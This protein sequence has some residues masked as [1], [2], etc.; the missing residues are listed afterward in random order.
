MIELKN[1]DFFYQEE[2]YIL[3]NYNLTLLDNK[4]YWLQG[5][6]GTG[7]TTLLNILLGINKVNEGNCY[8]N[9]NKNKTLF[10][11]STPFYEPYMS[12]E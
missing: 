11:P 4:K 5:K 2:N 3:K 9:Y 8:L 12:L 7:K 1:I 6:N 10:I